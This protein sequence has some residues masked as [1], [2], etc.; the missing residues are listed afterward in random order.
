MTVT[1]QTSSGT[2]RSVEMTNEQFAKY[3]HLMGM[4]KYYEDH[5]IHQEW[6]DH[7]VEALQFFNHIYTNH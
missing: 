1:I 7:Y 3:D 4:A 5:N 6:H 2:L